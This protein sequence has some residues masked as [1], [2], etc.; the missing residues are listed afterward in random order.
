MRHEINEKPFI[1]IVDD[2]EDN[3]LLLEFI[4]GAGEYSIRC[5]TSVAEAV[6]IMGERL[7]DIILTDITMPEIDGFEFMAMLKNNNRTKDIPIVVISGL[8]SRDDKQKA[9]ELGAVSF[10]GK[11]YD[12]FEIQNNIA[13]N[14]KMRR[15]QQELEQYNKKLNITIEQ[16]YK[17]IEQEQKNILVAL[18]NLVE[19]NKESDETNRLERISYNARVLAQSLSFCPAYERYVSPD[20][21]ETIEVASLLHDIGYIGASEKADEDE[22]FYA[23]KGAQI[24]ETV[25]KECQ[26]NKFLSMA[27]NIARYHLNDYAGNDERRGEDIPLA[28]RIMRIIIDYDKIKAGI[29]AEEDKDNAAILKQMKRFAGVRYDPD[30]FEIFAKII[31]QLK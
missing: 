17:R 18:A 27:I 2:I 22:R 7:P 10:L 11:P 4:L 8:D 28:A 16:Q 25:Y 31:N 6:E 26:N 30:I 14:V 24:L 21:V 19:V 23:E 13:I 20:Y 3:A 9:Y 12:R 15:M 5:A 29:P 1:L